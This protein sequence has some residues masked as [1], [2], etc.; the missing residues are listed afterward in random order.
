[1]EHLTAPASAGPARQ[2]HL[3]AEL[4]FGGGRQDGCG[5]GQCPSVRSREIGRCPP[6]IDRCGSS[7]ED[8][9]PGRRAHT[10]AGSP[11]GEAAGGRQGVWPCRQ[12]TIRSRGRRCSKPEVL[13]NSSRR[14][15]D[16]GRDPL[17]FA[18]ARDQGVV[19]VVLVNAPRI[20][21]DRGLFDKAEAAF[22]E[23]N[24]AARIPAGVRRSNFLVRVRRRGE[25]GTRSSAAAR[26]ASGASRPRGPS[27]TWRLGS[28]LSPHRS[29]AMD[30]TPLAGA[31]HRG[32][33][34]HRPH[35]NFRAEVQVANGINNG[36]GQG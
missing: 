31:D 3:F 6:A 21:P 30:R 27:R 36:F 25:T 26:R 23:K 19:P 13:P 18:V 24:R 35:P 17:N 9:T 33:R 29:S 28:A 1:M 5:R 4:F 14:F 15:S 16:G 11:G 8:T 10:P 34:W 12:N 7:P 2:H 20:G 22:S 32:V